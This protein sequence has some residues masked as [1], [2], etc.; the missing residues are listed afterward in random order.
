MTNIQR[1]I[2]I[3]KNKGSHS[4][5]EILPVCIYLYL[6]II[7]YISINEEVRIQLLV[8]GLF[9]KTAV[10]YS[11]TFTQYHRHDRA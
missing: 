11:P 3:V 2:G 7:G 8:Y 5:Y 9:L 10:T 1:N 4:Y 6:P